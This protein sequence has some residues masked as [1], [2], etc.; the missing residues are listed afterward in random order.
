MSIKKIPAYALLASLV[1]SLSACAP[2]SQTPQLNADISVPLLPTS[3]FFNESSISNIK[4]SKDGTWLAW[5]QKHNGISNIFVMPVAGNVSDAYPLTTLTEPVDNFYWDT[6]TLDMFY[7][8][9]VGGNEKQQIYQLRTKLDSKLTAMHSKRLTEKDDSRYLFIG[10][11]KN[12]RQLLSV[13]ANHDNSAKVDIYQLDIITKKLT[14][15]LVNEH[16]FMS[17]RADADGQV[18]VGLAMQSDSSYEVFSFNQGKWQS[19]LRTQPGE[20]VELIDYNE[21]Q[22]LAYISTSFGE[23]DTLSL[24]ALDL[25]D[26]SHHLVHQDPKSRS[27]VYASE[28]DDQGKPLMVSYYYGH[29]E[30]Y[31]LDPE[32]E[33][34]WNNIVSHFDTKVE[35]DLLERSE[36]SGK[37][38][39]SVASDVDVGSIYFYDEKTLTLGR[40]L[41]KDSLL[42]PEDMASKTSISYK[43]R[44]GETIQAYLLLPK[45][46]NKHLPTIIL[47]H[48]GPWA[49][50]YWTLG[51]SYFNRVAQ[52]LANRGYAVLQPNFRAS[53]GF[54]E[55]FYNLGNKNWGTGY[56]QHD[57]TDG[58]N[59]LVEQGIADKNR[60]G[61]MGGSYG[62]YAALAGIT[63]TPDIYQAAVSFVGPSSLVTLM[64]SFPEVY[65]PYLGN[66]FTA[67]GDP[68]IEADIKEME[69]RSP[70]NFVERIKTPLLLV[71]G[72]NDPRVTQ[73]ES[74][75]IAK[76]MYQLGLSV[77]YILAKDEGHGFAKRANNQAFLIKM[78]RFFGDKLGGQVL[79]QI[80]RD[81]EAHLSSLEVNVSAL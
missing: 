28:F 47:P 72:A 59:Y 16:N 14:R 33:E 32:F 11:V 13:M 9:D 19:L 58:A 34:H 15:T 57:L 52:L 43:A 3:V 6:E 49:R 67:V 27:D 30:N 45:G 56:M 23:L 50:D 26:G 38:L 79:Q 21:K 53:T 69:T 40:L 20:Q 44:D 70:I 7:N 22:Q 65:R 75:Q 25:T 61:I 74:D 24:V 55:R 77:E 31:F 12:N 46:K 10:Q 42:K 29:K 51:S 39:I 71:Q 66:W 64:N 37:W 81:M 76:K 80:P 17:V 1:L 48:G 41:Q 8:Q 73:I 18:R 2:T 63:F 62:G 5:L 68:L 54:G 4:M 60:L 36:D 35:I 78:E